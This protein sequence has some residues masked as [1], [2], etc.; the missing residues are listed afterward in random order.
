MRQAQQRFEHADQ[1]AARGALL[2]VVAGLDLHLGDLQVPVA[3][4]V[5]GELVDRVGDV[6]QAVFLEA[7]GHLGLDA[8]QLRDDPEVGAAELQVAMRLAADLAVFLR[9]L[10]QAAVLAFAVHQHEAR[11]VP[12]LVAEVAVALAALAVEVDAAAQRGQRGEGEA[13]RIG[14]EGRN[15][16]GEFLLRVLAHRRCGLGLAQAL[17]ALVEQRGQLDAV[18][19]VDRVEHVAFRLAH[20]LALGVAHQAVDVHVL[21]RHSAHEV[22]GHH[23]HPGDPEEDDVVARHEHGRGQVQRQV[24]RLLGPAQR[25]EG[26]QR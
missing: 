4:L 26:H 12:Q 23:D 19:Q 5:P 16:L 14:A 8:L 22:L 6:V 1:R 20:L 18:D 2:R 11:G 24:L 25:R 3:E 17:G 15:A 21:E 7:L 10:Q 9:V 13:Q